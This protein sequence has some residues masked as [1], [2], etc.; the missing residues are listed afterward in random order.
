MRSGGQVECKCAHGMTCVFE[1]VVACAP[2]ERARILSGTGMMPA[3]LDLESGCGFTRNPY[4]MVHCLRSIDV[5]D[6]ATSRA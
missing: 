1:F 6:V 2:T 4:L 3:A 5:Q